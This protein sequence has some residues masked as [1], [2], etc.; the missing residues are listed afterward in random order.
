MS[1]YIEPR[2][3]ELFIELSEQQQEAA[4]GGLDFVFQQTNI[5][6]FASNEINISDGISSISYKN[7][8]GYTLS[9]TTIGFHLDS[10]LEIDRNSLR[11]SNLMALNLLYRL[12]HCLL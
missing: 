10:L 6:S 7:Q 2:N 5:A 9:Q 4:A 8:S 1:N 3:S 12:L 11:K